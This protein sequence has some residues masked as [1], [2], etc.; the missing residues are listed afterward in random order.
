MLSVL[1]DIMS[2]GHIDTVLQK[3]AET[4]AHLFSMR[5]LVIGVLDQGEQIFRVRAAYGYDKERAKKIKKFTYT[6]ERLKQDLEEKYRVAS[7]VYL[8]RPEPGE[9]LKGEDPFYSDLAKARAPRTDPAVWHE[10]DYIRF[11]IRDMDGIPIGFIE[12]N[13]SDSNRIPD[14]ATIE[15]MLIFSRLAG[16]AIENARMFQ[17]QVEI[18]Q[19]SRF[20]SD[21]ISHDINN[22]NQAVTSY[23]QMASDSKGL[24]QK[25]SIYMERASTAAWGISELIQRANKL[26]KIEEEGAEHLGPVELGE[27]LKESIAEIMRNHSGKEVKVEMKLANHRYFATGNELANE[28]FTNILENAVEY[29][30]HDKVVIEIGIGEFTVEPRRYWCVSIADHGIGIPDSKKNLVFGRFQST[31]DRPPASG[32]GLSIVRA[33]VEAYHGIVWV[34]DRVSGDPSKGSVFRVSLPMVPAK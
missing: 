27:V 17:R 14:G 12:I 23:L 11:I 1:S 5:A 34:E 3:I 32:L 31:T 4:V 16:V 9:I 24:S 20:L 8:V 6:Q 2:V 29:D 33:I 15:A 21:I 13:E 10:L 25:V 18:A 7:D 30:P 28:I 26:M 19:R 22:Y